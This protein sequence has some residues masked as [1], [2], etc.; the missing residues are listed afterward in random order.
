M[1]LEKEM[2]LFHHL[3]MDH[4]TGMFYLVI[5]ERQSNLVP[6]RVDAH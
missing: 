3:Q 1:S 4:K 2:S 5:F 6:R